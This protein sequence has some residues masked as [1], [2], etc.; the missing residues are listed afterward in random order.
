VQRAAL[1]SLQTND[2]NGAGGPNM[3]AS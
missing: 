1:H 2:G 3:L